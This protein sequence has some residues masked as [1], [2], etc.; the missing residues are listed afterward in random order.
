M[1][2]LRSVAFNSVA[3]RP[4][5]RFLCHPGAIMRELQA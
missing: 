1:R 3:F 4:R 2:V 5:R